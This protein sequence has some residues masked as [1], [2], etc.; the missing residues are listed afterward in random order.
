MPTTPTA[1]T[2]DIQV[3]TSNAG[4]QY[5]ANPV[6]LIDGG[7]MV[8]VVTTPLNNGA[9]S[10]VMQQFDNSGNKVGSEVLISTTNNTGY[11]VAV[12]LA[13][14]NGHVQRGVSAAGVQLDQQGDRA[15]RRVAGCLV[16]LLLNRGLDDGVAPDP[17]RR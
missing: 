8:F 3:T 2:G 11:P 5:W 1:T 4:E 15:G 16:R 9:Y 6:S 13:G 14:G 17:R 12:Q 10:I 7:Y